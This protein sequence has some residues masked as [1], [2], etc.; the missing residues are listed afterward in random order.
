MNA[1]NE[2]A[3]TIAY[4]CAQAYRN[5]YQNLLLY[6]FVALYLTMQSFVIPGTIVLSVLS[7]AL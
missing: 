6:G 4:Q 1:R 2:D 5:Q 3:Y 7:G